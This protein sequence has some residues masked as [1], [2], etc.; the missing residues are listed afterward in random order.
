MH[1]FPLNSNISR[2]AS[3]SVE[4]QHCPQV[5]AGRQT[6]STVW[7]A[8]RELPLQHASAQGGEESSSREL[9][10]LSLP[11]CWGLQVEETGS[12][13]LEG[14]EVPN[15]EMGHSR[16]CTSDKKVPKCPCCFLQLG[17]T[18]PKDFSL[19]GVVYHALQ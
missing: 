2:S 5:A 19:A 18:H 10:C 6:C 13:S 11:P 4:V 8:Q 12:S 1:T 17:P 16:V 3:S 9:L 15:P 7:S 14:Q